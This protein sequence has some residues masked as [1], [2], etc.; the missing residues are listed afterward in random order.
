MHLE[1]NRDPAVH[2]EYNRDPGV[3]LENNRDPIVHLK[4]KGDPGKSKLFWKIKIFLI[5]FLFYY[6][7]I[8]I[9][10]YC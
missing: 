1:Y 4:Y 9:L 7:A 8:F 2:L 6:Q 5:A 10:V 3:S